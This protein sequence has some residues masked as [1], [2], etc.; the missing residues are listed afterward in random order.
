LLQQQIADGV[1]KGVV[2]RLELVEVEIKN[3]KRE[4]AALGGS[5]CLT[6]ALRESRPVCQA[7]ETIRAGE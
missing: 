2:D 1:A 4:S 3:R 7:G 6:E 5:E